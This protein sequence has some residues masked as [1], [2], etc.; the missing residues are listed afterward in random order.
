MSADVRT[1]SPRQVAALIPIPPRPY[2]ESDV[3]LTGWPRQ[4]YL[5]LAPLP[6][7]VPCA[8]LHTRQVLWEW[9]FSDLSDSVGLLVSE[10][11]TNAAQASYAV[12]GTPVRLWLLADDAQ[13]LILVW[14]PSP[15]APQP[16][17]ADLEAESGRG[18][19]LI[20]AVSDN[21]AW[22]FTP[23]AGGKAVWALIKAG[24]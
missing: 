7:A 16:V 6:G 13:V 12:G 10:L 20:D 11:V 1:R 9:A 15:A 17:D 3:T 19:L 24:H 8:R 14:D 23:E 4:D 21:W 2:G 18:L 5:E 22:Y